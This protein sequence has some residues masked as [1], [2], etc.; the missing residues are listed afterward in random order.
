MNRRR[1]R[2]TIKRFRRDMKIVI[3]GD[4][5]VGKTCFIQRY[6][7]GSYAPEE[8]VVSR[9]P[10]KSLHFFSFLRR[11]APHSQSKIGADSM[12]PYGYNLIN[13]SLF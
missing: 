7:K 9:E 4:A 10:K 12:S 11:S 8:S 6:L 5:A 3:L 13:E 2:A 1:L